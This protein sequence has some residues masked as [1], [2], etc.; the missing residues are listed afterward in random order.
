MSEM[1]NE[2]GLLFSQVHLSSSGI[3]PGQFA[4]LDVF[5]F[6]AQSDMTEVKYLNFLFKTLK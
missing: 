3:W 5:F 6:Y 1:I 4:L 2:S